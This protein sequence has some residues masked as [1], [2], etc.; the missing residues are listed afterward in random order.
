MGRGPVLVLEESVFQNV[1]KLVN[2]TQHYKSDGTKNDYNTI[3]VL[4]LN[5]LN[6]SWI[7]DPVV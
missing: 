2:K 7:E 3:L 1:S 5:I 6:I 4:Q